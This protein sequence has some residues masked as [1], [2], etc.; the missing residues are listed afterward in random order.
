[1]RPFTCAHCGQS[2]RRAEHERR[3]VQGKHQKDRPFVCDY[4]GC[5]R[6]F[7]R[8]DNMKQHYRTH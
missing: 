8:S 2:F 4:P 3:H 5:G 1:P 7:T 6:S